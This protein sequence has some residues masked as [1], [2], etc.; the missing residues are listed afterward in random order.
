M[1]LSSDALLDHIADSLQ[2]ISNA[3]SFWFMLNTSMTMAATSPVDFV[4]T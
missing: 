3:Q 1:T 2:F 4:W